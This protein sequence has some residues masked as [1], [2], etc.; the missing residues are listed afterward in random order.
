MEGLPEEFKRFTLRF[1]AQGVAEAASQAGAAAQTEPVPQTEPAAQTEPVPQTEPVLRVIKELTFHYGDSFGADVFPDIPPLEG[2]FSAWDRLELGDL[3]F[4]TDVTAV[5]TPYITA[6]PG[7]GRRDDGRPVFLAEGLFSG[8]DEF[9]ATPAQ[10]PEGRTEVLSGLT[11]LSRRTLLETWTLEGAAHTIRYLSPT[12]NGDDLELYALES[13]GWVK[14]ETGAAGSY[15]LAHLSGSPATVAVVSRTSIWWILILTAVLGLAALSLLG[16]LVFRR[17]TGRK[18]AAQAP[19]PDSGGTPP[20][21][22]AGRR[23]RLT[24]LIALTAVL[25]ACIT[26]F[27][28]T[29][30]KDDAAAYALLR[31]YTGRDELAA[32]LTVEVQAGEERRHID[33]LITRT[34]VEGKRVT[35]AGQFGATVYY[36]DGLIYLENGQAVEA[37]RIIPNYPDLFSGVFTLYQ[38]SDITV[39]ENPSERIYSVSVDGDTALSLLETMLP[40]VLGRLTQVDL[41]EVGL[42]ARGGELAELRFEAGG[43]F[44]GA[45]EELPL[46]V[47]AVLTTLEGDGQTVELP[48]RVR[49]RIAGGDGTEQITGEAALRLLES[50]FRLNTQDPLVSDVTL[51]ADCGPLVLDEEMVWSRTHADGVEVNSIRKNGRTWYFSE[52]TVY[53]GSGNRDSGAGSELFSPRDLL[54]LS[55]QLCI[56]GEISCEEDAGAYTYTLTLDRDGMARAAH[57]ILPDSEKLDLSFQSGSVQLTVT[58]GGVESIRFACGGSVRIAVVDAPVSMSAE[59]R[60]RSPDERTQTDIPGD[61]LAELSRPAG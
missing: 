51:S 11:F 40:S 47:S 17:R 36:C 29:G 55:Y 12:G 3:R 58:G 50:W 28:A 7:G 15:L 13:A 34:Q 54:K 30:L 8:E 44:A 14:L 61:V 49:E 60:F 26:V 43:L 56:N 20:A 10:L 42:V 39:F 19:A 53:D 35:C 25:A 41:L 9:T 52:E 38:G 21:K 1:L 45:G 22:T 31:R 16:A 32:R 5:Y 37:G 24:A 23:R 59:L 2:S 18:R 4:D 46:T 57:A 33:T 27:F 6:L 48:S